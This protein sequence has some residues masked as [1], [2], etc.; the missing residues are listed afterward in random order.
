VFD[1]LVGWS[2]VDE[3]VLL[4]PTKGLNELSLLDQF[5]EDFRH[6]PTIEPIAVSGVLFQIFHDQIPQP[7]H[8]RVDTGVDTMATL[9][10]EFTYFSTL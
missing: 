10:E 3:G 4:G 2:V 8:S 7:N 1:L 5:F 9:C 6:P